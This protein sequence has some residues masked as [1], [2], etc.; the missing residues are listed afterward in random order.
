M[1]MLILV[2]NIGIKWGFGFYFADYSIEPFGL[3][4]L[5]VSFASNSSYSDVDIIHAK[6]VNVIVAKINYSF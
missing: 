5:N 2:V 4:S 3:A 6:N 1:Y